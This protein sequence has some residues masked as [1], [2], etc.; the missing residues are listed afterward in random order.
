MCLPHVRMNSSVFPSQRGMSIFAFPSADLTVL[1]SNCSNA[2]RN[3]TN[4]GPSG[5]HFPPF[6]LLQNFFHLHCVAVTSIEIGIVEIDEAL[7]RFSRDLPRNFFQL[8][9]GVS[10]FKQLRISMHAQIKCI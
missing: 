4:D 7:T 9:H 3:I 5:M 10:R 6:L 8:F 2:S 1:P